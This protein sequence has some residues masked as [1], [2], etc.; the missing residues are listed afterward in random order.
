MGEE[1]DAMEEREM[2]DQGAEDFCVHD[3]VW[4]RTLKRG[5]FRV[6]QICGVAESDARHA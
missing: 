6:C 3:F 1:T 4:T 2:C 5:S